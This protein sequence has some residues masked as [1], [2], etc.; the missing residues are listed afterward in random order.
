M[1]ITGK[2]EEGKIDIPASVIADMGLKDGVNVKITLEPILEKNV[3]PGEAKR[4]IGI[5]DKFR[6]K[7]KPRFSVED[8]DKIIAEEANNRGG[9]IR[10]TSINSLF[11]ILWV[12]IFCRANYF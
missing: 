10:G 9:K 12:Q 7:D 4:I 6:T 11:Y 5:G 3:K 2:I 1:E 8:M